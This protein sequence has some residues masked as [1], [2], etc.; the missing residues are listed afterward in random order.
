MAD[1]V[2]YEN[3]TIL[4]GFNKEIVYWYEGLSKNNSI[5]SYLENK[6]AENFQ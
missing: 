5:N 4:T 6:S 2:S 3:G 1:S